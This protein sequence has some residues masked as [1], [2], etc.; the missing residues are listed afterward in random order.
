MLKTKSNAIVYG[1]FFCLLLLLLATVVEARSR[2]GGR[3]FSRRGPASRGSFSSRPSV[4]RRPSPQL[5]RQNQ[6]SS[7]NRQGTLGTNRNKSRDQSREDRRIDKGDRE[8][9]KEK[10]QEKIK[11]RLEDREDYIDD[12]WDSHRGFAV[13]GVASAAYLVSLPC[14]TTAVVVNG[15]SYYKCGSTW[16]K[17]GYSGSQVVYI[18]VDAPPG[19]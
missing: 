10:L 5:Q 18:A 19:Y 16:Y 1:A 2:A 7:S 12:H 11:D 17:R 3:S 6:L 13:V 8:E 9:I 14:T 15:V 4:S